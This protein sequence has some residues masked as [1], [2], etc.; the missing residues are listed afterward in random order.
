M[1]GPNFDNKR[2]TCQRCKPNVKTAAWN[3]LVNVYGHIT[4][5]NTGYRPITQAK[6]RRARLVLKW[7]TWGAVDLCRFVH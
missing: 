4:P 7:L 5:K 2:A 6:Q 3:V 1:T